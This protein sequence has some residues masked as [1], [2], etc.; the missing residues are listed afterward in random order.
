[1]LRS[2]ALLAAACLALAACDS[3]GDIAPLGGLLYVSLE[4]PTTLLL[5]SELDLP[6]GPRIATEQQSVGGRFIVTV[7]GVDAPSGACTGL[8]PV[9]RTLTIEPGSATT[10]PIDIIYGGFADEYRYTA[11]R[12][13]STAARLDSVRTDVTRLGRRP[14]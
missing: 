6:C 2:S 12:A 11:A 14:Q 4:S 13:G 3:G 5:E 9:R 10:F 1:L 8:A 7:L